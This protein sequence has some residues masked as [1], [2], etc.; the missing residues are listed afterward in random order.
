MDKKAIIESFK[1]SFGGITEYVAFVRLHGKTT[2]RCAFND[3]LDSLCKD[4][5]ITE[6]Q[7][8]NTTASDEELF[9]IRYDL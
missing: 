6:K 1:Q 2:T 4:G 3:Y 5:Q 8:M 9:K 7:R